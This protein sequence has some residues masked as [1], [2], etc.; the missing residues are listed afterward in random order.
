MGG[1]TLGHKSL[2]DKSLKEEMEEEEIRA[3][4]RFVH[5]LF[6]PFFSFILM[7]VFSLNMF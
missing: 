3:L 2:K 4:L 5:Y 7:I 6:P 1:N